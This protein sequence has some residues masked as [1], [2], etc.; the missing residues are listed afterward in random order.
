MDIA[1]DGR[2]ANA[3][4][5]KDGTRKEFAPVIAV[6]NGRGDR[7]LGLILGTELLIEARREAAAGRGLIEQAHPRLPLQGAEMHYRRIE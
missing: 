3:V 4:F 5:V 2:K 7:R 1:A 6:I